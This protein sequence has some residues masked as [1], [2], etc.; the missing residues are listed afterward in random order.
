MSYIFKNCNESEFIGY[1]GVKSSLLR[2]YSPSL[3]LCFTASFL[4]LALLNYQ[5]IT[6]ENTKFFDF[7][8]YTY[9]NIFL[10]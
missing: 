2:I 5:F 6:N 7:G 4:P 1:E 8:H 3:H 9:S 10:C